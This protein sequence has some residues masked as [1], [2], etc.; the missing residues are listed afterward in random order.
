MLEYLDPNDIQRQ[1]IFFSIV[2][3]HSVQQQISK[4]YQTSSRYAI[5]EEVQ[6]EP[7]QSQTSK[8][9]LYAKIVNG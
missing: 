8:M 6:S 4:T 1:Q 2:G 7:S 9:E 3:H 5:I